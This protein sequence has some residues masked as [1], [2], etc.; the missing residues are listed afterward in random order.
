M[1]LKNVYAMVFGMA[2]ELELGDNVRGF[3][4]T[5]TL[6]ELD[7]IVLHQGGLPGTPYH[8]AGLGDLITT[9][10]SD[11]PYSTTARRERIN[12]AIAPARAARVA[13]A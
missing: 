11:T 6:Q 13:M 3:L 4:A 10:T 12:S 8:L 9:A 1:I 5:A 7:R 2:D